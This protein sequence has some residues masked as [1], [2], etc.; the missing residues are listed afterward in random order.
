MIGRH[1]A[2]TRDRTGRKATTSHTSH[3][4]A[5]HTLDQV[6]NNTPPQLPHH[7]AL[8]NHHFPQTT[9]D[10]KPTP[11]PRLQL[12]HKTGPAKD[13]GSVTKLVA[14]KP[15]SPH[16]SS[17]V[18]HSM[19]HLTLPNFLSPPPPQGE[20]PPPGERIPGAHREHHLSNTRAPPEHLQSKS[21]ASPKAASTQPYIL[22]CVQEQ[23][24]FVSH[25]VPSKVLLLSPD[26]IRYASASPHFQ[27]PG[28]SRTQISIL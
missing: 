26:P 15:Q 6:T 14:L 5:P 1:E 28:F 20:T 16:I 18:E 19:T 9:L 10:T 8:H 22:S 11:R 27:P 25:F 3:T 7:C 4:N 23:P 2:C 24:L 17:L 13:P 12:P 21:K